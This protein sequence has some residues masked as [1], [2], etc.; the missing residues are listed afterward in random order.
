MANLRNKTC[1]KHT[2]I[3]KRAMV[4]TTP[5]RAQEAPRKGCRDTE[6]TNREAKYGYHRA[7]EDYRCH[8]GS[9]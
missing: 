8:S 3:K 9:Y 5:W 4:R 7:A 2:H 6:V 1:H